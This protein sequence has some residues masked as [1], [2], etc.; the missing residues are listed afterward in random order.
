MLGY[1]PMPMARL[2]KSSYMELLLL[3]DRSGLQDN[4]KRQS[5]ESFTP[6]RNFLK[7]S[8]LLSLAMVR[9]VTCLLPR[10][11]LKDPDERW[12]SLAAY[13]THRVRWRSRMRCFSS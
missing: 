11:G 4:M 5:S 8:R 12:G 7:S 10:A 13:S 3:Q 6:G 2:N 1:A 9:R